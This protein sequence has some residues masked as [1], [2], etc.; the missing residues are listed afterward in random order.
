MKKLA[1]LSL[2]ALAGA[3]A[4]A[5]SIYADL[6]YQ[7]HDASLDT[8]P[9]T[10]RVSM[11]YQ[12]NPQL[13]GEVMVGVNAVEGKQSG[14]K[15]KLDHLY[16]AYVKASGKLSE[17]VELYG[18]LGFADYKVSASAGSLSATASGNGLSYGI[19]VS[20]YVTPA[21]SVNVDYMD[22]DDLEGGIAFGVKYKF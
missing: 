19:G 11:G 20:Y 21:L 2:L 16:G 15:A 4:Q 18:R 12:F 14:V 13:A 8:D 5:Q 9:A 1:L 6:A 22:F 17:N 10:L 7:M 3:S